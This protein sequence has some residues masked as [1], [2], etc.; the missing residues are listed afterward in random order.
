MHSWRDYID[1]GVLLS[2]AGWLVAT[3]VALHSLWLAKNDS[4]RRMLVFGIYSFIAVAIAIWYDYAGVQTLRSNRET[5]RSIK[6]L[7]ALAGLPSDNVN[8][9]LDKLITRNLQNHARSF[10]LRKRFSLMLSNFSKM[11]FLKNWL[12]RFYPLQRR[13]AGE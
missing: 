6:T 8:Q 10:L 3:Y 4:R 2:A 13:T 12:L 5:E 7:L 11:L 9:G 1:P